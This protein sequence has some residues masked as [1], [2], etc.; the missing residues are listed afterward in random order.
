MA[1]L[2]A[3]CEGF[4]YSK[5]AQGNTGSFFKIQCGLILYEFEICEYKKINE[6]LL[7]EKKKK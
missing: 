2:P 1:G 3:Y 7:Y 4:W 6:V 5:Y